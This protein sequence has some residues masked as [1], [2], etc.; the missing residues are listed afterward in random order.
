MPEPGCEHATFR[1]LETDEARCQHDMHSP[2]LLL[3]IS[4]SELVRRPFCCLALAVERFEQEQREE[5]I[6]FAEAGQRL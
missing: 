1:M 2:P 5:R 3:P 4:P 6:S